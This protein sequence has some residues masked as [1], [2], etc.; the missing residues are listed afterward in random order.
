MTSIFNAPSAALAILQQINAATSAPQPPQ[1]STDNLIA[2]AHGQADKVAVSRQPTQAQSK[3]SEAF[4]GTDGK[5]NITK[6]KMDLIER[7]GKALGVEK[8]SFVS[9]DDFI[10]AMKEAFNKIK[11]DPGAIHAIEKDLGL[12]KLGLSLEDV[13]NSAKDGEN[14][15]KVTRAL[16]RQLNQGR[17]KKDDGQTGQVTAIGLDKTGLYGLLS[18]Y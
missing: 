18:F 17:D 2:V 12:D 7:T 8:D 5:V 11:N 4:F 3:V 14:N 9:M 15:D 13:I 16:E 6:L 1:S 10:A